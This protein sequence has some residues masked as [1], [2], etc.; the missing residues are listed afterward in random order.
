MTSPPRPVDI[1]E[2]QSAALEVEVSHLNVPSIW[3]HNGTELE[4]SEK[5]RI[6]VTGKVHQLRIMNATQDDAGE[7]SF[8]CGSDSK[9]AKVT[10]KRKNILLKQK[11]R[12]TIDHT[13][14]KTGLDRSTY[15]NT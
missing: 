14:R 6:S 12:R 7:Y 15:I 4:I 2:T 10:V 8:I 11:R 13:R 3:K 9:S 5:Y 1:Y